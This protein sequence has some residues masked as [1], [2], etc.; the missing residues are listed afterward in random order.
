MVS[1]G[2]SVVVRSIARGGGWD[3]FNF[4]DGQVI[5][6]VAGSDHPGR[7]GGSRAVPLSKTTFTPCLAPPSAR[8]MTCWLVAMKADRCSVS[9]TKPDPLT[10]DWPAT[11]RIRTVASFE[12]CE[13]FV[14]D[15]SSWPWFQP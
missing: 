1:Y 14:G 5:A 11:T 8:A 2:S 3:P 10:L 9:T 6:P 15:G 4:E 12:L 7:Q 13:H